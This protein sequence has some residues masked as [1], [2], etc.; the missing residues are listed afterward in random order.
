[1]EIFVLIFV[2]LNLLLSIFL[3]LKIKN[4]SD[5]S[6]KTE[7][8]ISKN[9]SDG[10]NQTE[11]R[12]KDEFSTNRGEFNKHSQETREELGKSVLRLSSHLSQSIIDVSKVQKDQLSHFAEQINNLT[13][14]VDKKFDLLR[15]KVE[16]RLLSIESKNEKKL[17]EMRA[18][19]DEKLHSTLELRLGESFKLV[20]ERLEQVQRG[21]GEMQSLASGVGDLKKILSN[22]KSRGT[23]GEIQLENLIEQILTPDQYG[24]QVA[25]KKGSSER[26]E[27]AVK[28]PGKGDLKS[29][30]CWIPIDAKFPIEDYQRLM[31][32]QEEL[33]Q[34]AIDEA[35]KALE[36]RIK[37]EAKSIAEKYLDPPNTTEVALMFL[38]VESLYAEVLR[39]PGFFEKIQNDYKVIITSPTTITAILNG[40]Q[41][42]FKSLAIQK[43]SSEVWNLLGE[44]KTEFTKFGDILDKTQKKLLEASN[45]IDDAA[46]RSRAIERKLKNV[47][48]LPAA[49]NKLLLTP[50]ND[51]EEL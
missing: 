32:A 37:T 11:K 6:S 16:E 35:Y 39:R 42:G 21:L 28:L 30:F 19:V 36:N 49:E 43:R 34:I 46:K 2:L 45:T 4:S 7:E 8:T 51:Q 38:P 15:D 13:G 47:Q 41:M 24:K 20:S 27:F 14:S 48:E 9:I 29:D 5:S 10:L 18:T 17:E 50:D 40:L 33:N 44:V 1:M 3:F 25:T 26:V 23:W 12:L 31:I 22:V